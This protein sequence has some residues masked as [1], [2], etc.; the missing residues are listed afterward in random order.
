MDDISYLNFD[1]PD[2]IDNAPKEVG[3]TPK[4]ALIILPIYEPVVC[5]ALCVFSKFRA[6]I[7]SNG[8]YGTL[9]FLQDAGTG[10]PQD[11][12]VQL[13]KMVQD[14]DAVLVQYVFGRI[15]ASLYKNGE[16]LHSLIPTL[17]ISNFS[18]F[19][20]KVLMGEVDLFEQ[21]DAANAGKSSVKSAK[22]YE[23]NYEKYYDYI[24]DGDQL[25]KVLDTTKISPLSAGT[26]LTRFQNSN[27]EDDVLRLDNNTTERGYF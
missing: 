10:Q 4:V 13:T 21:L 1:V 25:Q 9:A 5:G 16:K 23:I 14:M 7:L 15:D 19:A 2:E 12:I 27:D 3:E 24:S 6:V 18:D 22:F 20:E 17:V 26:I 11:L 8:M